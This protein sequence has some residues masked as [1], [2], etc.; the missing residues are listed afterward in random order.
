MLRNLPPYF[1]ILYHI[2]S[3]MIMFFVQ[4][5]GG[6][7]RLSHVFMT[8]GSFV[9]FFTNYLEKMGFSLVHIPEI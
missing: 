2:L 3:D 9:L 1:T 8:V 7:R 4:D 6:V 5:G